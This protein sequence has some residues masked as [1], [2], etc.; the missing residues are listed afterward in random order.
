MFLPG[1]AALLT[2]AQIG[3]LL[4]GQYRPGQPRHRNGEIVDSAQ[5]AVRRD[6]AHLQR[7]EIMFGPRLEDWQRTQRIERMIVEG[8]LVA[9][10]RSPLL[11][12]E[13]F[14]HDNLPSAPRYG[15]VAGGQIGAGNLQING[16][17][18]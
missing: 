3:P 15:G 2:V 5:D 4:P 1:D 6:G 10:A 8:A 13:H 9:L 17:L 18:T 11:G 14:V 7:M 12:L 16:W